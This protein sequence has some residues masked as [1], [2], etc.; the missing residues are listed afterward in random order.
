MS[1]RL[2]GGGG[3][4][5]LRLVERQ[6]MHRPSERHGSL[7]TEALARAVEGW[8]VHPLWGIVNGACEC[9]AH[10]GRCAVSAAISPP[11]AGGRDD[12]GRALHVRAE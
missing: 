6:E 5:K 2:E 12:Q 8:A 11:L 4:I 7:L 10:Q 3:Q 9:S 1:A